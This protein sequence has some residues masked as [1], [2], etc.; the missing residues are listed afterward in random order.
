M[1]VSFTLPNEQLDLVKR[2]YERLTTDEIM[3]RCLRGLT[4]NPKESVQSRLWR[5]CT[6]HT[7]ATKKRL[8][9]AVAQANS[10]YD[11]E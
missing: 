11:V 5:Y 9:F 6:K 4:Q 7:N 2:V 3:K 1:K 10:D 8:D